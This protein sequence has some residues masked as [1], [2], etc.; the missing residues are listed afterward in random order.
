MTI[1]INTSVARATPSVSP[2]GNITTASF[3]P[4]LGEILV[5]VCSGDLNPPSSTLVVT[6]S[7]SGTWVQQLRAD[8]GTAPTAN[9]VTIIATQVVTS[10][11]SMTV[12]LTGGGSG[13]FVSL[14]VY[15]VSATG[16]L[17]FGA[18]GTGGSTS[19][20]MTP[21][22]FTSTAPN[23]VMMVGCTTLTATAGGASSDLT[24]DIFFNASLNDQI[25]IAGFKS[26]TT[27]N[28]YTF[29]ASGTITSPNWHWV[30][31]EITETF[32][33]A[34]PNI[35]PRTHGKKGP[36][37]LRQKYPFVAQRTFDAQPPP[38]P[39]FITQIISRAHLGVQPHPGRMRTPV[40]DQTSPTPRLV[41]DRRWPQASAGL[42]RGRARTPVPPQSPSYPPALVADRRWPVI[43][44]GL[45]RGRAATPVRPQVN[46]TIPWWLLVDRR[47]PVA[48]LGL[49][50][51]KQRTPTA[52]QSSPTPA[53]VVD[54]RWPV[55]GRGLKRGRGF[56]APKP[57]TI[58]P[59]TPGVPTTV[60][61]RGRW[62]AVAA[63]VRRGRAVTPVPAQ[64]NPPYPWTLLAAARR[65]LLQ[66]TIPRGPARGRAATPVR[67]QLNPTWVPVLLAN[68]R[69]P[70]VG[71]GLRRGRAAE[72]PK[73][74]TITP[75]VFRVP[76]LITARLA[77]WAA[78]PAAGPR[79]GRAF[80]APKPQTIAPTPAP[81][82]GGR[83]RV[84]LVP[85]LRRAT[86]R[87]LVEQQQTG[88]PIR[89][90][91]RRPPTMARRGSAAKLLPDVPGVL[92]RRR[93][94]APLPASGRRAR[95]TSPPLSAAGPLAAV[96]AVRRL[97]APPRRRVPVLTPDA[98]GGQ[99]QRP[100]RARVLPTPRR[101]RGFSP[102]L[103]G[104]PPVWVDVVRPTY[105]RLG[106]LLR[107]GRAWMP[108]WIGVRPERDLKV[109]IAE[110]GDAWVF[111]E[112]PDGWRV[113]EV[114]DAWMFTEMPPGWRPVEGDLPWTFFDFPPGG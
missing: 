63:G 106:S 111:T 81:P 16:T 64:V 69:W 72:A 67:P 80:E 100:V 103:A 110:A 108:P 96:R 27:V 8:G 73:P 7:L 33:S 79:R 62:A 55:V 74:Q 107:R 114:G 35:Y 99:P 39:P 30:A 54:R 40:P 5:A 24:S 61:N 101:G 23:S 68:R 14:K 51:G 86:A 65:S 59:A 92:M 19:A 70:V 71:L 6:D 2:Q 26:L 42:K 17:G 21:T 82:G 34:R 12:T 90:P 28:S 57:N 31:L 89:T 104:K 4:A 58:A 50:R 18:T 32:G 20:S 91:R 56:E 49:K 113:A 45:K 13:F 77:R 9:H 85:A 78:T 75:T 37:V 66:A 87:T 25:I 3:T 105:R 15:R 112:G 60:F 47:W 46:P 11:T 38:P 22:A 88:L 41:V 97:L 48:A 52:E 94:P 43:A 76:E 95:P 10:A 98:G 29:N 93:A 102:W 53:L 44:A 84:L 83:R 36:N 1:S 109:K